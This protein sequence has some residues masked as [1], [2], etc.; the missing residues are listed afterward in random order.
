MRLLNFYQI[1]IL[2]VQ[3]PDRLLNMTLHGFNLRCASKSKC[4]GISKFS[5]AL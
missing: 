3:V 2:K 4:I 5:R 1:T